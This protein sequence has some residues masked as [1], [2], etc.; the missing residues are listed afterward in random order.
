MVVGINL[1]AAVAFLAFL[2]A[3]EHLADVKREL[4]HFA[5]VNQLELNLGISPQCLEVIERDY[6]WTSEQLRAV[7]LQW[8]KGNYDQDKHG[9]ASWS[10]LIHALEPIDHALALTIKKRHLL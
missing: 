7:L 3:P 8:L 1:A 6:R 4:G 5:N 10:A 9:V 2:I